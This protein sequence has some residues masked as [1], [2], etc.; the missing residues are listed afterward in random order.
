MMSTVFMAVVLIFVF[1]VLAIVGYALY[2][3]TPLPHRTNPYRDAET[4]KRLW[5]SPH[6][7]GPSDD[8]S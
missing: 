4:G 8:P 3:C 7:D 2:E 1:G 5:S 6:L